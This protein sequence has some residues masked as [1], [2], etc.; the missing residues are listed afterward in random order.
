MR[1]L[2]IAL[3]ALVLAA[4]GETPKT[5][6]PSS[7]QDSLGV[8]LVRL[9]HL[10]STGAPEWSTELIFST[11]GGD[12]LYF[13]EFSGMPATF[14]GESELWIGNGQ[15]IMVLGSDGT[16]LRSVGRSGDGPGEFASLVTA[17]GMAEDGTI[18]A[19]EMNLRRITRFRSDGRVALIVPRMAGFGE[20]LE[21]E[22]IASLDGGRTL[23]VPWQGRPAVD[24]S[25][26][27][28]H[29]P[30][31][32]NAVPVRM[33]DSTGAVVDSVGTWPGLQRNAKGLPI[34]FASGVVFDGRG[35]TTIIGVS[36][37]IDLTI[38]DGSSRI[39]RLIGPP[40]ARPVT[41]SEKAA[42]RD[43]VTQEMGENAS[44]VIELDEKL[45][46]VTVLPTV[47]AVVLDDE[48]NIWIGEY[49]TAASP[50]RRWHL[51]SATGVPIG[52]LA[53]P[54]QT[55]SF[56]PSKV[57]ILD[58]AHGRIALLREMPD[59]EFVVEVRSIRRSK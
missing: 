14:V 24:V 6:L 42:W 25:H 51:F 32:R 20:A 52:T 45:P 16:V 15:S 12:G 3:V 28:P 23:A 27:I 48:G 33:Y 5:V 4:C 31:L 21:I 35:R 8:P 57:E 38:F 22:V 10:D 49:V 29:G 9:P 44:A 53:L 7:A 56:I 58:V 26:G 47:G 13:G 17:L 2:P 37:S 46:G 11:Q 30:Y 36:D 59:G 55:R 43:G 18:S 50:T 1:Q 40:T 54:T 41:E 34:R 39:R 19:F